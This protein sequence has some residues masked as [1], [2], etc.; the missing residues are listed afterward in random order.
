MENELVGRR[1]KSK[2]KVK[3][4]GHTARSREKEEIKKKSEEEK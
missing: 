1:E 3:R 2:K 4:N